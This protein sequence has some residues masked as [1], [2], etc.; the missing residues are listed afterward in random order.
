VLS[1]TF[2]EIKILFQVAF[3]DFKEVYFFYFKRQDLI[4]E[5]STCILP[6]GYSQ[7]IHISGVYKYPFNA[8]HSVDSLNKEVL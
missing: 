5:L 2:H 3:F 6:Y 8:V 7:K 4:S 1:A